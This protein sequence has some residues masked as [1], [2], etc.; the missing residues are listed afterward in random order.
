MENTNTRRGFTQV[1]DYLS[2]EGEGGT[3]Y[4]ERGKVNKAN[5]ICTPSSALR[6]SSLSRGKETTHAFTLI[7]LLVVVLIIGILAAVAVPQYRFAVEKSRM[8]EALLM[9]NTIKKGYQLCVL[10]RGADA[11]QCTTSLLDNLDV[12]LPGEVIGCL[13]DSEHC[14]ATKGWL[15]ENDG[16]GEVYANRMDEIDLDMDEVQYNI[17]VNVRTG[18]TT[19]A[20]GTGSVANTWFCPKLC[21]SN[22]CEVK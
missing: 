1:T 14:V 15:Y 3:K 9:L 19:C 4:R 18:K 10:Q 6:A 13:D 11:E 5:L 20:N 8:A 7:E 22:G 17:S 12:A 16:S 2:L 21:G